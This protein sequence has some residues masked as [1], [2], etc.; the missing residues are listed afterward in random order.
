MLE[1]IARE[2]TMRKAVRIPIRTCS[3]C[4]DVVL[5]PAFLRSGLIRPGEVHLVC[6]Q[7]R[8]EY[9]EALEREAA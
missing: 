9:V 1:T 7:C 5:V 4:R 3:R 2:V 6:P 8:T